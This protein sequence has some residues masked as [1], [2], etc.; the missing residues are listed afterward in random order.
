MQ[1]LP[2]LILFVYH[3]DR[4]EVLH[5]QSYDING[6]W[7]NTP[8]ENELV[9]LPKKINF[10]L[11]ILHIVCASVATQHARCHKEY[12]SPRGRAVSTIHLCQRGGLTL[13]AGGEPST[14]FPPGGLVEPA[15]VPD[16]S[17]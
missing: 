4:A 8:G 13:A 16:H 10:S 17:E 12:Y 5:A 14:R 2:S 11:Q 7:K 9:T 6:S 3:M 15:G 1:T